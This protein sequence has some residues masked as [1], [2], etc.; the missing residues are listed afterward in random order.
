MATH[1]LPVLNPESHQKHPH[2]WC[3]PQASYCPDPL[4]WIYQHKA[5]DR[6]EVLRTEIGDGAAKRYTK[7]HWEAQSR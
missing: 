5:L 7:G 3:K 2:C 4:T 1:L 6:E